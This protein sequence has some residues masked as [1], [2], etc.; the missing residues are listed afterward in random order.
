[1]GKLGAGSLKRC[2]MEV[3]ELI[4]LGQI[5]AA[6]A[7][8]V[9]LIKGIEYLCQKIS[10]AATKWLQEGLEPIND[11]LDALDKKIDA[12]ELEADKTILVRFLADIK[13]GKE[14]TDVERE[15]LHETYAHYTSLHGNSYVHT[16]VEKLKEAGKL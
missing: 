9:G 15:R 1:M 6:I 14:L 16:E 4:T 13:N 3:M 10:H 5:A 12:N 7:F 11:K 8:I 2:R